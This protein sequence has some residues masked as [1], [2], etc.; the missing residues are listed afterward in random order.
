MVDQILLG[1]NSDREF[2]YDPDGHRED[3]K[4]FG[5]PQIPSSVPRRRAQATDLRCG[6]VFALCILLPRLK[7][8]LRSWTVECLT[9]GKMNWP[10]G[11]IVAR[12]TRLV[13]GAMGGEKLHVERPNLV[14]L[15]FFALVHRYQLSGL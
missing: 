10:S 13:D 9:G 2:T 1:Q 3:S 11:G 5:P 4:T 7:E 15:L 6:S 8:I 14:I 12:R